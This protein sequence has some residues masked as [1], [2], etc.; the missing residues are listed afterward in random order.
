MI[1]TTSPRFI[2]ISM[3]VFNYNFIKQLVNGY[4]EI[5]LPKIFRLLTKYKTLVK[6]FF[7]GGAAVVV[8]LSFLYFLTEVLVLWYVISS[9]IAFFIS[10]LTGFF[11]QKFW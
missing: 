6:Y 4:L 3:R 11:L 2:K 1:G 7:S 9:I 8:N 5:K 10:L